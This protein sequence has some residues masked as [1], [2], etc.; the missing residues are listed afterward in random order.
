MKLFTFARL[1]IVTLLAPSMLYAQINMGMVGDSVTDDYL[2]G[3]KLFN[4]NL[5]AG[6]WGQIL[7]VTRVD[8]FNFGGYKAVGDTWDANIRYSGYEFN[9][10][11]SGGAASDNAVL[12]VAGMADPLPIA[13]L[14]GSHLGAQTAG[15]AEEIAAG[16]VGTAYV[17]IGSNDFFYNSYILDPSGSV[18][19]DSAVVINQAFIDDVASSIL[20]GV[21]TLLA[22]GAASTDGSVDLLLGLVPAGTAGGSS[23]EILAGIDAVNQQLIDGAASRGVAIV[24]LWSWTLGESRV[25]QATDILTVGGLVIQPDTV[26]TSADIGPQGD[27]VFC[28][29][30]GGCALDSH[31]LNIAAEDGVHPNTIIQGL[32]ANEIIN[33]LNANYGHS[34][35]LL[36]DAEIWGLAGVTAVP[37]PAAVW[38]FGSALITLLGINRKA[39]F[40][41]EA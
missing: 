30:D 4:N 17:G 18:T 41:V 23:P 1:F 8:D 10:A 24:D 26:A 34:V 32:M 20:A 36:T 12:H 16:N 31:A 13:V 19:L 2:G 14:G 6:S 33:A 38:L 5:A 21:D 9:Y 28:N 11:T 29:T 3:A 40:L 37:V 35:E 27:G 22:A 39:W 7:A 15:L 25:D